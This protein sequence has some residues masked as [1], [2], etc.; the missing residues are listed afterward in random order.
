MTQPID[1]ITPTQRPAMRPAGR[2]Q[3]RNLLFMHWEVDVAALRPLVPPPLEL[4]PLDGRHLVGIVPFRMHGVA[5]SWLPPALAF[6]FLECNVRC[7]VHHEGRPGVYFFSLDAASLLAVIAARVGWSLPYHHARMAERMPDGH[8]HYTVHRGARA[9]LDVRYRIGKPLPAAT[10]GTDAFFLLERYLL[11]TV[12][13]GQLLCGQ[14]HHSPYPAWEAT[15]A[16]CSESL[17]AAAGLP[18]S[19]IAPGYAHWSPG[20][21]VDVY[22]LKAV[23]TAG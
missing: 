10:P 7:Y 5:P 15:I 9:H 13:R 17:L 2:Q 14:V 21:D 12:R 20:V 8:I 18:S 1:R 4:D 19:G 16:S 3:W 11:F 6:N 23:G 22:S